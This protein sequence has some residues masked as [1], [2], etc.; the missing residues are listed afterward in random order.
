MAGRK[1]KR[2]KSKNNSAVK[3]TLPAG[4]W[5]QVSAVLV[6]VVS[7]VMI[8][9]FFS[10]AGSLPDTIFKVNK[11]LI[12][13]GAYILPFILIFWSIKVFKSENNKVPT[14]VTLAVIMFLL[15]FAGFTQLISSHPYAMSE[16]NLGGGSVGLFVAQVMSFVSPLIGAVI[17][18]I[19]ML[20]II[21]YIASVNP[22]TFLETLKAIFSS[23]V[24]EEEARITKSG[25]FGHV[26]SIGKKNKNK[27][28]ENVK[29]NGEIDTSPIED[30][31][32]KSVL[33]KLNIN[34][35]K[36]E[37]EQV[38][39]SALV[40]TGLSDWKYPSLTLL[41]SKR[42]KANPGN[43]EQNISII[44]DTYA[45]FGYD[46]NME[47]VNV[48]PKVTQYAFTPPSGVVLKKIAALEK[49]LQLNLEAGSVR[50]EAPIPGK[51]V[52]G[53]E[54]PNKVEAS[55]TLHEI[56]SSSEW[57][58][59]S[60][61]LKFALG[62]DIG[63]K[64]RIADLRKMPHLLVA[65]TTGSGKSV[66]INSLV[67]SL[68][69]ANSPD[70]LRLIMVDPKQVEM[71]AYKDITHLL[72]PI[73]S[74]NEETVSAFK[75]AVNEMDRRY[76]LMADMGAKEIDS[77]NKMVRKK[78]AEAASNNNDENK[79]DVDEKAVEGEMPYI[80]IVVD[81]LADLMMTAGK[82]VEP[83]IVRIAQKA[84]AAGIHLVLATQRPTVN[85]I[86]GLI[87]SN[88]PS[89][90]AFTVAS[91]VDS[92]TII[93]VGGAEKLLGKGDMLFSTPSSLSSIRIQ[94]AFISDSEVEK[95]TDFIRMQAP[96]RYNA[97]VI[98][99]PTLGG[100][101]GTMF[102]TGGGGGDE[103]YDRAVSI[104]IESGKAS[105]SNLQRR[106]R[107]GYQRASF[108]IDM[109]EEQGIVGPLEG[110]KRAVL[111]KS[112]DELIDE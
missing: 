29:V 100:G 109:M 77:Y 83:L 28:V 25:V 5:T 39:N 21:L 105:A 50:I 3:H 6:I 10:N 22:K 102:T 78:E 60:G 35:P 23:E 27:D 72:T 24:R 32:K 81:E 62:K 41:D 1:R 103:L 97:D 56:L 46:V 79:E 44:K 17:L 95:V 98:A 76:K 48:G 67:M 30:G 15:F 45:Q 37:P 110:T 11:F 53:V 84:R 85:V 42:R 43:V 75:W 80:V 86:T 57:A 93:D 74:S 9:S 96:P 58:K 7:I 66:M 104:V 90:I 8:F 13:Y 92:K 69:Y 112:M 87:K 4:F 40:I 106:L 94:G 12:G 49:N 71:T 82:E 19:L 68:V 108:L 52:V 63:G 31:K 16:E 51:S 26:N 36:E 59:S 2:S 111:V 34:K 61:A 89:R 99:Q 47:E 54:V 101:R 64:A 73:I 33:P 91:Q 70:Q 18:F 14:V 65:G 107:I 20:I 55:V 38:N 88:V